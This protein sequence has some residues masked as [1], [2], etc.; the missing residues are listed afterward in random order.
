MPK[1]PFFSSSAAPARPPAA[2]GQPGRRRAGHRHEPPIADNYIVAP[3]GEASP[4]RVADPE[5]QL[6]LPT[7]KAGQQPGNRAINTLR[8]TA[9]ACPCAGRRRP[10]AA[11]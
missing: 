5:A 9:R 1:A 4:S 7:V 8:A 3:E 6:P 10:S 11:P 2:Q